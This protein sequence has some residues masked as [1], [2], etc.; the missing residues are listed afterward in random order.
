MTE[1]IY[2]DIVLSVDDRIKLDRLIVRT[3]KKKENVERYPVIA[4]DMKEIEVEKSRNYLFTFFVG[5]KNCF[6]G[7]LLDVRDILGNGLISDV[8][9]L[10]LI[11]SPER[12]SQM[13]LLNESLTNPE[14]IEIEGVYYFPSKAN[15]LLLYP[16]SIKEFLFILDHLS[17]QV[18]F[19]LYLN[20]W[21]KIAGESQVNYFLKKIDFQYMEQKSLKKY[22]HLI[23]MNS[24]SNPPSIISS[25]PQSPTTQ[26]SNDLWNINKELIFQEINRELQTVGINISSKSLTI[27][28]SPLIYSLFQ[29]SQ[30]TQQ[31]II[32][33]AFQMIVK[34]YI[35]N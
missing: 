26:S 21:S 31:Q 14:R 11:F 25:I 9:L 10:P 24:D 5:E 12:M 3:W 28:Y 18:F 1:K 20:K 8:V 32:S 6:E 17:S 22:R 27:S 29:S 4:V 35:S 23:D 2:R 13:I 7:F 30:F 15:N 19:F 34:D 16:I 33:I